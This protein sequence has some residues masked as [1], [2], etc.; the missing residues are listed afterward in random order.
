MKKSWLFCTALALAPMS[1]LAADL[2]PAPRTA[3][4]IAPVSPWA[5]FYGGFSVGWNW[6]D[7]TTVSLPQAAAG[8]PG[9]V[10]DSFRG[11]AF[12]D[13]QNRLSSQ[14]TACS[15]ALFANC[16][17]TD[18]AFALPSVGYVGREQEKGGGV[19]TL[20]AGYN[21]QFGSFV[22]GVEGDLSGMNRRYESA[23]AGTGTADYQFD[24]T[25]V[26]IPGIPPIPDIT[27][28][29]QTRVTGLYTQSADFAT[30]SRMSWLT[31]ARVRAGFAAGDFLLYATG[32]LAAGS[33]TMSAGGTVTETFV[34]QTRTGTPLG[35]PTTTSSA[36][37]TT[38]WRGTTGNST[39]FGWAVGGGVEWNTGRGFSLK[40]EYL[41]Y[42]LGAQTLVATGT[43]S[44][45]V[46]GGAAVVTTAPTVRIRQNVDGQI[47]RMGLNFGFP[48][49][50]RGA[51]VAAY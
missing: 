3:V 5:G 48:V 28:F 36:S 47:F 4:A 24:Y 30:R 19:I 44:T 11:P 2:A 33:S 12:I 23:Y 45:V 39:E 21:W 35:A 16:T 43:T 1:A 29:P 32:G 7:G 42:D 9:F 20:N 25:A 51:V 37:S 46:N 8:Q 38:T 27:L 6:G 31:T 34:E 15:F 50:S 49:A 41:Y 26:V 13:A 18:T 14:S 40:A 22:L 10:G 17:A